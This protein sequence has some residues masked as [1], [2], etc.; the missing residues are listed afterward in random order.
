MV[1]GQITAIDS[2]SI[3]LQLPNGNSQVIFYSSSTQVS[4]PTV[5]PASALKEGTNVVVAGTSSSDGSMA[6]TT[7]QVRTGNSGAP[8]GGF[9]GGAAPTPGK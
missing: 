3:T 5:V 8:A 1:T 6:A 7:I 2:S 9:G 4:E